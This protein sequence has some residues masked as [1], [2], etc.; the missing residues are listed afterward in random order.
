MAVGQESDLSFVRPGDSIE[1]SPRGTIVVNDET[2][3]TAGQGIFAGGDVVYGPRTLIEAIADGHKAARNIDDYLTSGRHKIMLRAHM[4]PVTTENLP[5]P[6]T[7]QNSRVSPLKIPLDRRT[8]ISEVE[9]ASDETNAREQAGR[10]LKCHIQTVFNGD[11]CILC[12]GC[13]DVCPWS[14]LKMVSLDKIDG[15]QRVQEA[16]RARYGIS[17][18]GFQ[19]G[20]E[21]LKPGTAMLKDETSCTRCGL[22]AERCPTGAITMEAFSFEE[23]ITPEPAAAGV[24][25]AGT[26][27]R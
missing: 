6:E 3:A 19:T 18:E 23:F 5:R 22:C 4:A 8:G 10:C 27:D 9:M 12:G 11:L 24:F 16:V 26:N 1:I 15:D 2:L 20:G 7:R 13:V 14:C 25:K 21:A 17:Q